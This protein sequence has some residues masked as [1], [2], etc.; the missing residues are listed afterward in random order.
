MNHVELLT[1]QDCFLIEGRGVVVTPDFP[2]H[3]G[4]KDRTD[5]VL[6]V[7][8]DGQQHQASIRFSMSHFRMLDPKASGWRVVALLLKGK[9]ED[10]PEGSKILVSQEVRD[11][12]LAHNEG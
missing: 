11:A 1:V 3:H 10:L 6:V 7:K 9:K 4:W 12:I 5:T 8:P 2:V